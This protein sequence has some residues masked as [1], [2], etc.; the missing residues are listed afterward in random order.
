MAAAHNGLGYCALRV[1][2]L[3]EAE[4]QFSTALKA[5]SEDASNLV[6]LGIAYQ[7]QGKNAEA[8]KYFAEALKIQPDNAEGKE[9]LAKVS[10][11]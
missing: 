5:N 3:K 8:A 7:R 2:D 11:R 6:G 9:L 4:K 10:G 1:N